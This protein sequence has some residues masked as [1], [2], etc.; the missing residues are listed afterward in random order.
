MNIFSYRVGYP[1]WQFA[2]KAGVPVAVRIDVHHDQETNT[3][4]CDSQGLKGFVVA[5]NTLDDLKREIDL[6]LPDFFELAT[7]GIKPNVSVS[8]SIRYDRSFA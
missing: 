8:T 3:Y 2:A 5:G 7:Q 4:W 1:F 6:T